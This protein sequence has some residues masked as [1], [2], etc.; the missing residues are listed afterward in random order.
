MAASHTSLRERNP[1]MVLFIYYV[2]I[3]SVSTLVIYLANM[4]FPEQVVLGTM[5]ISMIWAVALSA[6]KLGVITTFAHPFLKE[7][8][9]RQ[10]K[11]LTPIHMMGYYLVVNFAALWFIT[12]FAEIFG[13]GVSSWMVLLALAI[14]LD[15]VQ[16]I[17]MTGV[18]PIVSKK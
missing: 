1:G 8:E 13:L 12:R 7:W 5:S 11:P 4:F 2:V 18:E 6:G 16:G 17:A 14:V 3:S 15:I 10:G 9:L